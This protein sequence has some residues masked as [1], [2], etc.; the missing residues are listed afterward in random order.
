MLD[1]AFALPVGAVSDPITTDVGTVVFKVLE[2]KE[3]TPT[4]WAANNDRFREELLADGATASSASYMAKAKQGMSI[5]VNREAL[6]RAL[7]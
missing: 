7:I 2:K 5:E 1:A 6:Q 4:E 3:V